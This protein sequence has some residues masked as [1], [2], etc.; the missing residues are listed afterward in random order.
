M[1]EPKPF[2]GII[3]ADDR[4]H[5]FTPEIVPELWPILAAI[6]HHRNTWM[7]TASGEGASD[8]V[9][10]R[11]EAGA[12]RV[13]ADRSAL[14]ILGHGHMCGPGGALVEARYDQSLVPAGRSTYLMAKTR[15]HITLVGSWGVV[16][17]TSRELR[18]N[19]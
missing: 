6:S 5:P 9:V 13:H 11:F 17:V 16:T 19:G 2:R 18:W 1:P 8:R 15:D 3:I 14:V 10:W 7:E 4:P 12:L